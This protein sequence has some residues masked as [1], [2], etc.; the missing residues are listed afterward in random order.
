MPWLVRDAVHDINKAVAQRWHDLDPLLP[1]PADLPEGC[2]APLLSIGE[3]GRP[4]G[5]GVCHHRH[6]PADSLA[7]T[8]G[9]ATKFVLT[10]RLRDPH[11]QADA[12]LAQWREHL[13]ALPEAA[14]PDTAAIVNW[15]ARDVT[16]VLAL[17]RHGLQPMAVIAARPAGRPRPTR[18]TRP[19]R[20]PTGRP[21]GPTGP[22]DP[23][24]AMG[25]QPA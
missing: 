6:E 10:M 20:R 16:G 18:P 23:A 24:G 2:M 3:N 11:T 22:T 25:T 8:W 15:P 14:G 19:T 12:L 13:A 21:T 4:A 9:A 7:Q 5:L 17:L 1:E